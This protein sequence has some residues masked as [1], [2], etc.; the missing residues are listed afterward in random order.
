[1]DRRV[2]TLV[3]VAL[4][5]FAGCGAPGTGSDANPESPVD[6]SEGTVGNGVPRGR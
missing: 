1:M 2:L 5:V 4:V 3:T 6:S